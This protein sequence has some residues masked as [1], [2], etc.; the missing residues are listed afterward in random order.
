M[1][2]VNL[3]Q[4]EEDWL[5]WRRQGVTA[6]DAAILLNRS[7]YKTR[8]RLWA[9]KTGYAREVDLSLNPLV[10][11]GIESEDAARRAFEEKGMMTCCSP[12]CRIGS[13]PPARASPGWPER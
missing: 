5:D 7:P 13:I 6:T 8:W 4:R 1:K 3:S 12:P 10:R 9:E 11:R 2:I